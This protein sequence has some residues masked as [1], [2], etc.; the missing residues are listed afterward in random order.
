MIF[1]F[2]VV[3]KFDVGMISVLLNKFFVENINGV[4]APN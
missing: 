3:F 2:D 1:F 4:M